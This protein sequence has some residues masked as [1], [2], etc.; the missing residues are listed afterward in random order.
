MV[1]LAVEGVLEGAVGLGVWQGEAVGLEEGGHLG[2]GRL[3]VVGDV[4]DGVLVDGLGEGFGGGGGCK[5]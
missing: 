5:G 2:E 3:E 1:P 4:E